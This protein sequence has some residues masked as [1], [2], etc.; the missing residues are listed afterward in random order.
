MRLLTHNTL[1]NNSHEAQGKGYP[2][3]IKPI[4]IRVDDSSEVGSDPEREEAF[5]KGILGM[6]D[7]KV[8]LKVRD[9]SFREITCNKMSF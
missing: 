4:E 3:Q 8:L 5:V 6:L 7:W 1:R 2:L 9:Q